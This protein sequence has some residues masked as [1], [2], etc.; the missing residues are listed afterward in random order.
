[1]KLLI[2]FLLFVQTVAFAAPANPNAKKVAHDSSQFALSFY[3]IV[4][5]ES[6]N[7]I[8]SPYSIFTC[9]SMLYT[10]A[11]ENT[12][13]EMQ[14]VLGASLGKRNFTKANAALNRQLLQNSDLSLANGLWVDRDTFIL[15]DF[16][17]SLESDFS[18]NIASLDFADTEGA[19]SIIN[20]WTAN[21]TKNKIPR[22]LQAGDVDSSTRMVLTNALYFSGSFAKPF[23]PD[24]TQQAD[25]YT[26]EKFS[27]QVDM[28]EQTNLFSFCENETY[29]MLALPFVKKEGSSSTLACLILLPP[30]I[31]GIQDLEHELFIPQFEDQ[32]DQ[33]KPVRVHVK[34]P[35]FCLDQRLSLND[36]LMELGMKLAFTDKANFSGIDGMRDLFLNKVVHEAFFSLDEKGVTASAATAAAMNMTATPSQKPP[37][38]FNANHPFLFM[39]VDMET[40]TILFMGKLQTPE[41]AGCE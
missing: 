2:S 22:L 41:N 29:Q 16:R 27:T 28:M 6:E 11:R 39:L 4:H 13:L 33:L 14:D 5:T 30:A 40:K 24:C 34:L 19:I 20:E 9:L 12:A 1:M 10:G 31:T 36:A 21:Q 8:F 15:S 37:V 3:R 38:E 32:M 17:H 25:F 23:D 18:A 7:T 26:E 35:K